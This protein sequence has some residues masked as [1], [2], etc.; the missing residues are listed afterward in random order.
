MRWLNL[1]L[2]DRYLVKELTLPFFFS[3]GLFSC[4][5]VTIGTL[6]DLVN[7]I[8]ESDL[9]WLLA[10]KIV[11]LKLPEF[12][13]YA[14]PI[15][16]LLT[17]LI[18]YSRLSKDSE[19]IAL[20]SCGVSVYRFI[21]PALI[22][23]LLVTAITFLFNELIVPAANYQATIILVEAINEEQPFLLKQDIFYPEYEEI[24]GNNGDSSRLLKTL[25]YAQNFDGK[26]MNN[27]TILN[28]SPGGLHNIII[29]QK[30][31]WNKRE[32]AWDFFNG[33]V[34]NLSSD[35][36]YQDSVYFEKQQ[37]TF[38]KTPLELAVQSRDPY[39]MNI[40]QARKYLKLLHLLGDEKAILIF[41][42]R[43]AQKFSFPFVCLIF[44]LVGSALG[45]RPNSSSKATSFGLSVGIVFSYY[46]LGFVIGSLGLV[47]IL[48]PFMAAWLPNF[49][50][51]AIGVWLL[52]RCDV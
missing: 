44:A 11:F 42:V 2:T 43:T 50:G 6:S 16:V 20:R 17:T 4:L 48:T 21:T 40:I 13:A 34:Y 51:L 22:L 28:N 14:L 12:V 35:A 37:F 23:S 32:K 38:P 46:L 3:V 52:F 24:K 30:A 25:F 47:A 29:S 7:K 15:S 1:S 36:S 41:E 8:F 27:L 5:G 39:D 26:N 31:V 49:I 10:V 9:S 45:V 19:L 18:T 33:V